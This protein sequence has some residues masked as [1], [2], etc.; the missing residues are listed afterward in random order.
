MK[1]KYLNGNPTLPTVP[2]TKNMEVFGQLGYMRFS[3]D[4][5]RK[6][7]FILGEEM[8]VFSVFFIRVEFDKIFKWEGTTTVVDYHEKDG[9]VWTTWIH[10]VF[11]LYVV[12]H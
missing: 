3:K 6:N 1:I 5:S 8:E 9:S 7:R 11:G 4:F 10:E 12:V 2:T